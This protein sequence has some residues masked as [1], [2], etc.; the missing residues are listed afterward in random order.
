MSEPQAIKMDLKLRYKVIEIISFWE[1]KLNASHLCR[2]FGIGRQQASKD[3]NDYLS[4]I[5]PY[6]LIYDKTL[7]GYRPSSRFKPVFTRG[8]VTEY[9]Q[10]LTAANQI[11]DPLLDVSLLDH[12]LQPVC[13]ESVQTPSKTI[14]PTILSTLILAIRKKYRVETTYVSLNNPKPESRIIE[15]HTLVFSGNRWHVRA[16]CEKNR[17][18]R[19]FVLSRFRGEIELINE[20]LISSDE[21]AYW[22]HFVRI[23]IIPDT[24]LTPAQRK[25]VATDYGMQRNALYL[26]TRA[27][28]VNYVLQQFNL[29]PKK[30][31]AKPEAQQ[32]MIGNLSEVEK[33]LF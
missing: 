9:L 27:A 19:D 12:S 10:L 7:K 13:I 15:P 2:A 32:L 30:I 31:E 21:D 4:N 8:D 14:N 25:V 3:I 18:F 17:D 16:Y 6:N 1:G 22:H 28:L 26:E 20:A 23:K 5:A 29:D 33:W 11:D 24:R